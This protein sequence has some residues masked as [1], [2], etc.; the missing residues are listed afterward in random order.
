M[1][2]LWGK[3][4]ILYAMEKAFAE[5]VTVIEG[6]KD[7]RFRDMKT[8]RASITFAL[9]SSVSELQLISSKLGP[10][11][12]EDIFKQNLARELVRQLTRKILDEYK[13]KGGLE[14]TDEIYTK[15]PYTKGKKF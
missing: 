7:N 6:P 14:E 9:D 4:E 11:T 8:Y 12:M 3:D 13:E 5:G 10:K 1:K 15:Y 2:L